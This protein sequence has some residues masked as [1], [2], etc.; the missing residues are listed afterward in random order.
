MHFRLVRYFTLTSLAF[1]VITGGAL[2]F[3]YR[4]F[5]V[6]NMLRLQES[7]NV[8]L[9][10]V[11]ANNLW[12][13][14]LDPLLAETSGVQASEL[15]K[16]SRI[17]EIHNKTLELMRGSSTYK[18][19][20]YDLMG[21]TVY[22]SELKQIGE[23]KSGNA[24]FLGAAGG[25]TQTELVHKAQFS[26]FE[27][28]VENRDLIQSYIPQIDPK[29]DRI[30]GV[31]EIYSDVT[32]FLDDIHQTEYILAA[33][34]TIAFGT[35]YLVLFF[36]VRNAARIIDVQK[37]QREEAQQQ[38]AQSEKMAALGQLVAGVS[39]Q[40]NTPLGFSHS[41]VSLA[42]ETIRSFEMPLRAAN[43]L[44]EQLRKT[45]TTTPCEFDTADMPRLDPDKPVSE[46]DAETVVEM[47]GDV[48]GGI[49]QMR[50][51]V[52]SLSEFTRLERSNVVDA[53]LNAALR[54]VVYI[55]K[56]AIPT[57]ITIVE[58]YAVL[59]SIECN[60]SQ[61]NQVF[62]NLITNAAQAIPGK[63]TV[64]VR[65][66]HGEGYIHIEVIDSGTGIPP[67][68]LP[69]IFD[70]YFTTKPKGIGTGLGL[71]IA[72]QIVRSHGGEISVE[73]KPGVG[74]TFTVTL[75]LNARSRPN[76]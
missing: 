18:I 13:R 62:L 42:I 55:A 49:E 39:H 36:I 61:L 27:K 47:L 52:E 29:T 67:E 44:S 41:N 40:L 34:I 31:F 48:I 1:F 9:T 33:A 56:S 32:S 68:T 74:S 59:P 20:V 17:Q 51:L 71:S 72:R 54:T 43:W 45:P 69:H 3:F 28:V 58:D 14:H 5:T 7:G 15:G 6:G 57:Q 64:T 30:V 37:K 76:D 21:R 66:W 4:E 10:R 38:L 75:P 8:N 16:N 23:D 24:G 2:A 12:N 11:L 50:H 25:T 26:A 53:D 22:S 19:K 63:G 46:K 60:P 70:T 35:L 65:T 73:S